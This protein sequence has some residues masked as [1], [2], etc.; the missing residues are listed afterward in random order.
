M[1]R[2]W[3][4]GGKLTFVRALL[5]V[6]S[7]AVLAL[8]SSAD[9]GWTNS[10]T[11]QAY[12]QYDGGNDHVDISDSFDNP[13]AVNPTWSSGGSTIDPNGL[14]TAGDTLGTFTVTT[15]DGA[16]Y[17][18]DQDTVA[19]SVAPVGDSITQANSSHLS[20]RYPLWTKLIDAGVNF[21][22]VGSLDSNNG[23][24]PDWPDYQGNIFDP[25][26]EGHWGWRADQV[27]VGLPGWLTSYTP[28]VALLHIGTNDAFDP[29]ETTDSTVSDIEQIIDVLR[30]D[31]PSI[32]VLLA[33]LIPT[34]NSTANQRINDLNARIVDIAASKSTGPSPVVVVDQNTGFSASQDTYDG[35]HPDSSGEEKMA[36]KWF[37][38][39]MQVLPPVLTTIVVN[40]NPA[41]VATGGTVD[42]TAQGLDQN[43]HDFTISPTWSVSGGGTIDPNGPVTAVYTAGDI[44]GTFTVT[45]TDGAVSGQAEVTVTDQTNQ[46]VISNLTV[47]SGKPYV[48]DTSGLSSGDRVYIDRKFT[49]VLAPEEVLQGAAFIQTANSDKNSSDTSFLSFSV[50]QAVTVYVAYDQ[51][52]TSLPNWLS[53]GWTEGEILDTTDVT[54]Q[55]YSRDFPA[56][57]VSLG[58]NKAAGAKGTQS[59]YT[60]VIAGL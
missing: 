26:H 24:N 54:L 23:G 13:I 32:I 51:Q 53:S 59:N 3:E 44:P 16:F 33:K 25:D 42:F 45:A 22:L 46:L 38:A 40:P 31:N 19:V 15:S 1:W 36:Q 20:Y 10:V 60:V 43:G 55:L 48:V 5:L 6:L 12:L 27:L 56:G 52:A 49:Y 28:D 9:V 34:S 50:N 58:G 7:A 29:D 41:S 57:T 8:V 4:T 39:M 47:A 17:R 37:E 18:Q 21:D 30:N 11:T 2:I 35:I 14:Y